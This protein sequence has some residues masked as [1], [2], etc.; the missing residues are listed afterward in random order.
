M[1]RLNITLPDDIAI[2]LDNFSNKSSFIAEA[3]RDKLERIKREK[4]DS[5][6]IESYKAAR[7]EEREIS[8]DWDDIALE[9][10]N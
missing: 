1:R 4:L 5:L 2:D 10:W 6:L 9:G 3:L 8:K 7:N